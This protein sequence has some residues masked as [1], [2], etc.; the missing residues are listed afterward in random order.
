[1]IVEQRA[2]GL[3][4]WGLQTIKF[5]AYQQWTN[6]YTIKTEFGNQAKAVRI[7]TLNVFYMI[8]KTFLVRVIVCEWEF[9]V[10]FVCSIPQ[11]VHCWRQWLTHQKKLPTEWV[12]KQTSSS[13]GHFHHW[14]T[15]S[16]HKQIL[17]RMTTK[18]ANGFVQ[19]K[20]LARWP[21]TLD[22]EIFCTHY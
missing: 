20:L 12:G 8:S 5:S 1:M 16:N 7:I 11:P 18:A 21:K 6:F 14:P 17:M 2:S 13:V 22:T 15:A 4:C 9:V 3:P 19:G 10:R